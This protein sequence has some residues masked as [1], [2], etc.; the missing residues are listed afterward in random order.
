MYETAKPELRNL[1]S[2][3]SQLITLIPHD[4]TIRIQNKT[5]S[6]EKLEQEKQEKMKN[7]IKLTKTKL[8][9][10]NFELD[11]S[12]QKISIVYDVLHEIFHLFGDSLKLD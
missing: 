9:L 8:C 3:Y 4:Q 6:P 1:Y 10:Y 2:Q 11:L 12:F 7:R 5:H